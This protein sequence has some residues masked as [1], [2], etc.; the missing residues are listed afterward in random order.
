[1]SS[2]IERQKRA[3][4]KAYRS[5]VRLRYSLMADD[6]IGRDLEAVVERIND[7]IANGRPLEIEAAKVYQDGLDG[8][9][10]A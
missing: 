2:S 3:I 5:A 7:A 8:L 4:I 1:M 10:V 9:P 6:E